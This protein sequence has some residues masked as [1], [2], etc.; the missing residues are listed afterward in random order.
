M[1]IASPPPTICKSHFY[2]SVRRGRLTTV[3]LASG[4]Q[5]QRFSYFDG[6]IL[7]PFYMLYIYSFGDDF[8]GQRK[9]FFWEEK[10]KQHQPLCIRKTLPSSYSLFPKCER[11]LASQQCQQMNCNDLHKIDSSFLISFC[12]LHI[13]HPT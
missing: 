4:T 7:S 2:R 3:G 11:A 13:F 10:K 9:I 1:P 8:Q 12:S 6:L 5:N